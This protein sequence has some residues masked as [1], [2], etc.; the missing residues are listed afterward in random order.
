MRHPMYL[1]I[2]AGALGWAV[3]WGSWVAL[4]GTAIMTVFL[5]F[6]AR[7]EERLLMQRY[8]G[9][10]DYRERVRGAIFPRP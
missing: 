1:G 10:A 9:Y 7:R 2:I 3:L 6:K 8:P 4:A 5:T